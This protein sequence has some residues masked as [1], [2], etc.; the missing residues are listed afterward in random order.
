[1]NAYGMPLAILEAQATGLP[2]VVSN[3][4]GN[5]HLVAHDVDGFV[6]DLDK[7]DELSLY[8]AQFIKDEKLRNQF[9]VTGRNTIL[10]NHNIDERIENIASLYQLNAILRRG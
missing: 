8:I 4:Q 7:P 5:S 6:F 10:K 2:C 1:M 9:G 3:I